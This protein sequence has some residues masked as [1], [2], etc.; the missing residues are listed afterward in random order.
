MAPTLSAMH[1]HR[2]EDEGETYVDFYRLTLAH[3][4]RV[5]VA[6]VNRRT[7]HPHQFAAPDFQTYPYLLPVY[8]K[9]WQEGVDEV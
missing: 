3:K 1:G 7:V 2:S 8:P 6:V 9:C 4:Q 5:K